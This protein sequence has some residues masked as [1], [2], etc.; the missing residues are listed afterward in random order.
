MRIARVQARSVRIPLD[1]PY[2][3]A[4][5]TQ[6]AFENVVVRIETEDGIV[7]FGES[8]PSYGLAVQGANAIAAWIDGQFGPVLLGADPFNIETLI[9]QAFDAADGNTDCVAPIDSALWDIMGKSLQQPVYRL[10]GG[11]C[12]ET[13]GVDFSI[14]SAE[15]D[16]M[17][18]I[19]Q[20]VHKEGYQGVVVKVTGNSVEKSVAQVRAVRIVLPEPCTV[21]VDC[22]EGFTLEAAVRFLEGIRDLGVEFVEQPVAAGDLAGLQ[23]CRQ[24]GVPI[25]VDESLNTLEDAIS[26]LRAQACDVM[27]IK[28]PKVGGLLIAKKMAAIAEAARLPVVVGGKTTFEIS[29]AASRHFAAATCAT[30]GIAHEGPGP[31]SQ[32][33]I[34]DVVTNRISR[35]GAGSAGGTVTVERGP[36]L[37]IDVLWSKVEQY[38]VPFSN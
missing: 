11:L 16:E 23:R 9:A 30:R 21:R 24:V 22:N 33:L 34:D 19:A 38:A 31:A 17:A 10:L 37:G 4:R 26:I 35:A 18:S 20:T 29:R 2:V 3:F 28:P 36:G 5:G 13:I 15:P 1:T 7:G 8:A 25:S 27:N 32:T 6:T 14:S 12:H